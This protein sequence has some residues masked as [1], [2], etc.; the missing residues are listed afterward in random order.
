MPERGYCPVCETGLV[1]DDWGDYCPECWA[2]E[3]EP[4]PACGD[5]DCGHEATRTHAGW[6]HV[7]DVRVG[8]LL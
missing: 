5:V 7:A 8:G 1:Y 2:W 3:P 6:R 4:C